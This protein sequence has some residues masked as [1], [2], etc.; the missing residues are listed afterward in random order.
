MI[1]RSKYIRLVTLSKILAEFVE[2]VN[3]CGHIDVLTRNF[4][5]YIE[6]WNSIP[7]QRRIRSTILTCSRGCWDIIIYANEQSQKRTQTNKWGT[8][9]WKFWIN[10]EGSLG[11]RSIHTDRKTHRKKP[12]FPASND[13]ITFNQL[14]WKWPTVKNLYPSMKRELFFFTSSRWSNALLWFVTLLLTSCNTKKYQD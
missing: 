1:R 13:H 8:S 12:C 3:F 4:D 6:S 14:N 7:N 2:K 11:C 10:W 5:H 9:L